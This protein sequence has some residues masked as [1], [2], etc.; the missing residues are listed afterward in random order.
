MFMLSCRRHGQNPPCSLGKDAYDDNN[1]G[2][3]D[4]DDVSFSFCLC[5]RR[6]Q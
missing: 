1:E 2:D 3:G 5:V 4:A 6:C